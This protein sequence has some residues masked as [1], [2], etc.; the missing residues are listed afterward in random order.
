MSAIALKNHQS[1]LTAI[2]E[3]KIKAQQDAS[4]LS[5]E[6]EIIEILE[7]LK[8]KLNLLYSQ[9]N[10]VTDP[11]LIDSYIYDIKAANSRYTY[12]LNRCK[13]K[14]IKAV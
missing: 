14:Q 1:L 10:F 11:A 5:E 9:L 8:Q 6:R 7:D 13:E 3:R 2:E 12:Y 4:L